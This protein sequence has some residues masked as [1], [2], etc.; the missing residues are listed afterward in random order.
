MNQQINILKSK[1]AE[2]RDARDWKQFHNPKD[3]ALALSIEAT[4]LMEHFLWVPIEDTYKV[5]DEKKEEIADEMAD[6][7]AYL[8]SLSDITGIDLAVALEEKLKKNEMKYPVEKSKGN[9][10]K[11]TKL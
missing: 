4:E 6:V 9:S 2:F 1:I 8:L 10:T 11:Y 5:I 3:L 7:F